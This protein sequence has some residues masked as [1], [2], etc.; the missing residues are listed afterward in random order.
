MPQV[1]KQALGQFIRTNCLRQLALN[2]YPDNST[3]RA[4]RKT[5]EMPYPQSPRPGLK[6][7]QQA[8]DD[9]Q[10]EKLDDLTQTFGADAIIGS[11]YTTKYKP[12][13]VSA[14]SAWTGPS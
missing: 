8:G 4:D 7:I 10:V 1:G 12:N 14:D 3:Y 6:Q 11:P 5:H 2:L 13:T 9:W